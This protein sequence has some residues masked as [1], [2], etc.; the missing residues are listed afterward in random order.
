MLGSRFREALV[1]AAELHADQV[2]KGTSIPYVSHL[3]SVAALVIEDGGSEDEAVAALLHDAVEDQGGKPTLQKIRLRFGQG[4]ADIVEACSDAD[5]LPKPPWRERKERYIAHLQ[6]ADDSVLRV[7]LADKL[8]NARAIVLDYRTLGEE[9]WTRFNA[10]RDDIL[11]YYRS[12]LAVLGTRLS[13]PLVGELART[14]DELEGLIAAETSAGVATT[15]T[16]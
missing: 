11:W 14:V 6:H 10:S 12:A 8:H 15:T 1:Y 9:L 7:A 3:L 16:T 13:S 2:R 5:T 4:V